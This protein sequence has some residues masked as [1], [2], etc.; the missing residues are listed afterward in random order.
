[1]LIWSDLKKWILKIFK[2]LSK[3]YTHIDLIQNQLALVNQVIVH[4]IQARNI[5]AQRQKKRI[6]RQMKIFKWV[7][8]KK[9]QPNIFNWN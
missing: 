6:S 7:I 2:D 8:Y 4:S 9:Q 1:M 5:E 3:K